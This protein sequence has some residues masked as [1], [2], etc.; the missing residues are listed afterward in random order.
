[1]MVVVGT[2][3]SNPG[4]KISDHKPMSDSTDDTCMFFPPPV[5]N[6]YPQ[7]CQ[8]THQLLRKT[9][10]LLSSVH[11]LDSCTAGNELNDF[12]F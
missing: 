10:V 9:V 12:I 3:Y 1:M 2:L 5:Y 8:S 4:L 11:N 6:L 7:L